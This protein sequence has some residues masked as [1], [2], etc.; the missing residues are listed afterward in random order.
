MTTHDE[1]DED[2]GEERMMTSMMSPKTIVT[3]PRDILP[4][5][6]C[7][8]HTASTHSPQGPHTAHTQPTRPTRSPH[9]ANRIHKFIM[10]GER[11]A[12]RTTME[13]LFLCYR[14]AV[15]LSL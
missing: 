8:A 15:A 10:G 5:G 9:T 14:F 11:L 2:Y 7:H 12:Q 3:L 4:Q 1:D 6:F 13:P